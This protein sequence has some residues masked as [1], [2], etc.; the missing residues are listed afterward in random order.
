[1]HLTRFFCYNSCGVTSP[2]QTLLFDEVENDT[3]PVDI[4]IH[5]AAFDHS[6]F[7]NFDG[8][9]GVVAHTTYPMDGQVHFDASEQWTTL[10]EI[11]GVDLRYVRVVASAMIQTSRFIGCNA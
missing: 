6:D 10:S 1:M 3:I 9:G 2:L 4:D 5:F 7:E 11:P 8:P